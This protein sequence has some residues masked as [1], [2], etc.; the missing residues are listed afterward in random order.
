VD[1]MVDMAVADF[2]EVVVSMVVEG[3]T[4]KV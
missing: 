4:D 1:F 3:I 2:T